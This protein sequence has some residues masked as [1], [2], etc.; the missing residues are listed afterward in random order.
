MHGTAAHD[1]ARHPV[2]VTHFQILIFLFLFLSGIKNKNLIIFFIRSH[3]QITD[4]LGKIR[5]P[6][7][8]DNDTYGIVRLFGERTRDLVWCIIQFI[9]RVIYFFPGLVADISA[10]VQYP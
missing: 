5:M 3:F 7:M 2:A 4:Q 6:Y 8:R 1:N 9:H 10:I